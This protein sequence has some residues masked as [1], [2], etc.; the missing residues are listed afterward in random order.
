MNLTQKNKEISVSSVDFVCKNISRRPRRLAQILL[1]MGRGDAPRL[2]AESVA[3]AWEKYVLL[4]KNTCEVGV[5][6]QRLR[7]K[8]VSF[9]LK[10]E[11]P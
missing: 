3:S 11:T 6:L 7:E 10:T 8:N 9:C 5:S 1:R 2:S 4:S